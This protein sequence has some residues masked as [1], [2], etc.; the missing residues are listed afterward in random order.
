MT[1]YD[2]LLTLAKLVGKPSEHIL[3][4][5]APNDSA[6]RPRD[7]SLLCQ[8]LEA[9]NIRS[10]V[11]FVQGATDALTQ[12]SQALAAIGLQLTNAEGA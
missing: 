4:A 7:C 6:K 12:S 1:K 3:P 2:M 10:D 5:D 9:L 8:R 11:D